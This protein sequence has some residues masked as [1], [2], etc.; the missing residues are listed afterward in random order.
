MGG[1][2]VK[3][4]DVKEEPIELEEELKK[5]NTK[6]PAW[7]SI[8]I[9]I[10][11]LIAVLYL[12]EIL[13]IQERSQ[14]KRILHF[15]LISIR[16]VILARIDL[17]MLGLSRL[18]EF[19]QIP[20]LP[21][22]Q[23]LKEESRL[24]LKHYLGCQVVRWIDP[25]FRVRW[26]IWRDSEDVIQEVS[27]PI[28]KW[29]ETV[30]QDARDHRE[31]IVLY[32]MGLEGKESQ[33]WICHPIF[34]GNEF[35][36][37]IIGVFDVK[38]LFDSMLNQQMITDY[39]IALFEG[40]REIYYRGAV[41]DKEV[42]KNWAQEIPINV[43]L[44]VWRLKVWPKPEA[45]SQYRSWNLGVVLI[46]GLLLTVLL[47][48][49]SY[50]A[51][52]ARIRVGMME[53]INRDLEDEIKQ[54]I[55]SDLKLRD[56]NMRTEQVIASIPSILIGVDTQ[57]RIIRWNKVAEKVLGIS[58]DAVLKRSL[59][60]C[61]LSWDYA[62]IMKGVSDCQSQ[63]QPMPVEDVH[64][65][66]PD[67][68]EGYLGLTINFISGYPKEHSGF[69]IF[70]A[71]ITKR[72]FLEKEVLHRTRELEKMNAELVRQK[73]EMVRLLKDLKASQEQIKQTEAQ[74]VQSAKMASVGQLA[75]GVAHEINNPLTGI[76]NNIYL[77]KLEV[78]QKKDLDINEVKEVLR[79]IEDSALRC[80]RI[81]QALLD[82]SHVS[83]DSFQS[84]S[85]NQVVQKTLS[86][87]AHDLK[88]KNIAI[89]IELQEDLNEIQGD[90]QRLQQVLLDLISNSTWAIQKKS[91][92]E[93]G[94]ITIKS[95]YKPEENKVHLWVSDNGI[96][97]SKENLQRIFEP[98]FTTKPV[99]QGTGL[100][101]SII[102][103]IVKEHQGTIEVESEVNQGATFKLAFPC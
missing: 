103:N 6:K 47:T 10:V 45:L 65:I 57:G 102:F 22:S 28:E 61:G 24:Y 86:L 100:G 72:K 68:S 27:L 39:G 85:L 58:S 26:M 7:F 87:I 69:L 66:H 8:I 59:T 20:G 52:T 83:S 18:S 40:D 12:R 88:L 91:K 13:S 38:E 2:S 90:F 50:L 35:Y 37:F 9:G 89:N 70:G 29:T 48:L 56:A 53:I 32:S 73:E 5:F 92:K 98:F 96:G 16:D 41:E 84:V 95:Q 3:M 17:K 34:R 74:L 36:G 14:I 82:F 49:T 71:D 1:S 75:S 80:K 31:D 79:I 78:D 15:Q 63:N 81:T 77:V 55:R 93:E 97:I 19:S 11:V 33:I 21:T 94:V 101:L 30:L 76:L 25:E 43:Y 60:E 54:R 46:G 23:E 42:E 51:Q 67:G 62:L 4:V 99:G 64:F 44:T